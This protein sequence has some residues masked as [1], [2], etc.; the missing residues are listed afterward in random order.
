MGGHNSKNTNL[1]SDCI[2]GW[3]D[4]NAKKC[5]RKPLNGLQYCR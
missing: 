2:Y 4:T 1:D 3:P 5:S